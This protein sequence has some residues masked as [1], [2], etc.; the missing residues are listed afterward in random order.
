MTTESLQDYICVRFVTYDED[1]DE[2][3]FI[4]SF[5]TANYNEILKMFITAK[6]YDIECFFNDFSDEVPEK[7]LDKVFL[8]KDVYIRTGGDTD[9]TSIVVVLS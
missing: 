4:C 2:E 5:K 3:N 1:K 9:I 6:Q 7:Y 8:V